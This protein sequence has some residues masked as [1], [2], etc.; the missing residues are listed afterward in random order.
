[1]EPSRTWTFRGDVKRTEKRVWSVNFYSWKRGTPQRTKSLPVRVQ[2]QLSSR[3]KGGPGSKVSS[4]GRPPTSTGAIVTTMRSTSLARRNEPINVAP[5]STI[6]PEIPSSC[7][8]R[9]REGSEIRPGDSSGSSKTRPPA[10][11]RSA[12]RSWSGSVVV[13]TH[14]PR[15]T[16]RASGGQRRAASNMTGSGSRP[17]TNRTFSRGSSA[18]TVPMPTRIAGWVARSWCVIRMDSDALIASGCPRA[19]VS[20]PSRLCA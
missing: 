10:F 16:T 8:L 1:M 7:N 3:G 14:A 20:D 6:I 13:Q 17:G 9:I 2:S 19:E 11:S 18:R 5:P 4:T 15:S 12:F